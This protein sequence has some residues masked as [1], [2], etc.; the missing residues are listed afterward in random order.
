VSHDA[1]P[2]LGECCFCGCKDG[3]GPGRGDVRIREV[4]LMKVAT[5][6]GCVGRLIYERLALKGAW[7]L[8]G[9]KS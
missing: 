2:K 8:V 3:R 4:G 6:E 7:P 1:L 9:A 5:C